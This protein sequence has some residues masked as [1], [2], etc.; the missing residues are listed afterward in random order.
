MTWQDTLE[1][2]YK[3]PSHPASFSGP[4][5]LYKYVKHKTTLK[6]VKEWLKSQP[7]YT[8]HKPVRNNFPRN[9]VIVNGIDDQWDMDLMDMQNISNYNNG[10]RFILIA[11]D[12]FSRYVWAIPLKSKNAQ[13]MEQAI[14]NILRDRKPI[15]IRTDKGK[16]FLASKIQ[17]LLKNKDIIHF[18]TENVTKANYAEGAIKTLKSKIYKYFTEN[19]TYKYIDVL[20]DF[21]KA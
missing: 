17:K 12:V 19:E 1:K 20:Q 9:K 5:K 14:I 11:I 18:V 2:I 8:M 3:D 16:E 13:D 7:T 10:Y 21:V 4:S 15:K 6:Q